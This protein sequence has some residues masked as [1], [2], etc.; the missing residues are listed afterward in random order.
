MKASHISLKS[1]TSQL[2]AADRAANNLIFTGLP[3]VP[4]MS[5]EK[6]FDMIDMWSWR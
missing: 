5:I 6:F 4:I 2:N 1:D 3:G